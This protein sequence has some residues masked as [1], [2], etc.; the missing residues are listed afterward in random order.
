LK[1]MRRA[2]PRRYR[3]Q[4]DDIRLLFRLGELKHDPFS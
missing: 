4:L 2:L 3:R 1:A